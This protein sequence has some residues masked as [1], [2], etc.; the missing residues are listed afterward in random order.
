VLPYDGLWNTATVAATV[1]QLV[2]AKEGGMTQTNSLA[3]ASGY[4]GWKLGQSEWGI[5]TFN[6]ALTFP[7]TVTDPWTATLTRLPA[8]TV[9][10]IF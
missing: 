3:D 8:G 1:S 7:G 10:I 4:L 5:G 2:I 6:L 9:I